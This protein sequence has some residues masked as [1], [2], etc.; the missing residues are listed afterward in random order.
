MDSKRGL[1]VRR[2]VTMIRMTGENRAG[3]IEL[4]EQH[5]AHELMRPSCGTKRQNP[6]GAAAQTLRDTVSA[7]DDEAHRAPV[8]LTAFLQ[9]RGQ[10]AAVDILAG[11]VE[12]NQD[13]A[14]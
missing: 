2:S 4:L 5:D 9:Q 14:I 10:S 13:R 12:N 11:F 3:A 8:L 6:A 7:A 1:R